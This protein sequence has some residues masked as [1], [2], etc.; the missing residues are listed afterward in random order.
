MNINEAERQQIMFRIRVSLYT[1]AASAFL[2]GM[3]VGAKV[4]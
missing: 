3:L 1:V 2:L 4:W